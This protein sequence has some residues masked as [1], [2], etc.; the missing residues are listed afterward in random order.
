MQ[1]ARRRFDVKIMNYS[2]DCSDSYEVHE[3]KNKPCATGIMSL[4]MRADGMLSFCRMREN[5]TLCLK[6]KNMREVQE[7]LQQ[8]LQEFKKCYHYA[9]SEEK[10][11]EI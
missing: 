8:E 6:D 3:G 11:E 4:T 10:N 2:C 7:M 9:L 5:K 1:K